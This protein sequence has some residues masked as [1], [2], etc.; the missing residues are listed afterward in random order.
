MALRASARGW[1]AARRLCP[2]AKPSGAATH[3]AGPRAV[4]LHARRAGSKSPR[5][6]RAASEDLPCAGGAAARR[7]RAPAGPLPRAS[8]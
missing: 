4:A 3:A 5:A 1:A 2:S 6:S 8:L 7:G